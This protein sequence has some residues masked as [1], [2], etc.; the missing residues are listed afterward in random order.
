VNVQAKLET[1]INVKSATVIGTP[2]KVAGILAELEEPYKS[3]LSNLLQSLESA[4][5]LMARLRSAGFNVG[6]TTIRKHRSGV[7]SC[8]KE[9]AN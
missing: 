8:P 4:D 7:C 9:T 3:S 2:C 6:A 1:L 5:S